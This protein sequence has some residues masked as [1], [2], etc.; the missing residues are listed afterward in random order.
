MKLLERDEMTSL[1]AECKRLE[2]EDPRLVEIEQY[3]GMK[4]EALI[5]QQCVHAFSFV[6]TGLMVVNTLHSNR[7]KRAMETGQAQRVIMK[8]IELKELC[9]EKFHDNFVFE[10]C[11][12]LREPSEYAAAR[13]ISLN[14]EELQKGFYVHSL[15]SLATSLTRLDNSALVKEALNCFKCILGYVFCAIFFLFV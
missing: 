4:K 14:R 12:L 11:S 3:M 2:H 1:Y 5:K 7:Y 13:F 9:L 8:E 6:S 15:R 10:K